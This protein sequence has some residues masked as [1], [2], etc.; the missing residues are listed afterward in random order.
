M[1]IIDI[2]LYVNDILLIVAI[3]ALILL[4]IFNLVKDPKAL[5]FTG[6]LI[7]GLVAL[8]FICYSVSSSEVT[9]KYSAAGVDAGSS[10]LI[11]AGLIMLYVFLFVSIAAM[12]L[13]EVYKLFK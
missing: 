8:F 4:E 10:Q 9:I 2:G 12:V 11:G 7:V 5:M 3:A 13:S 1:D 6:I